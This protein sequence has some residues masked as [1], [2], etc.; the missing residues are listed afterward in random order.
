MLRDQIEFVANMGVCT[1]PGRNSN[2]SYWPGTTTLRRLDGAQAAGSNTVYTHTVSSDLEFVVSRNDGACCGKEMCVAADCGKFRSLSTNGFSRSSWARYINTL[3]AQCLS[4][5]SRVLESDVG[6]A[7]GLGFTN[8]CNLA[9]A[10]LLPRSDSGRF[11]FPWTD[12]LF[13]SPP[14]RRLTPSPSRPDPK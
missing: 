12:L 8:D 3:T 7:L 1:R 6:I 11:S 10:F 9:C 4:Y 13:I 14:S 2:C 5:R